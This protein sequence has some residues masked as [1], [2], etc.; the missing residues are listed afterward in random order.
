MAWL[1][2]VDLFVT[3]Q[4]FSHG[5]ATNLF[6]AIYK[7]YDFYWKFTSTTSHDS[8]FYESSLYIQLLKKITF[9]SGL[10]IL[11]IKT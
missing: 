11:V 5:T 8:A 6:L 2:H 9:L 3:T 10:E 7:K 4:S 1:M